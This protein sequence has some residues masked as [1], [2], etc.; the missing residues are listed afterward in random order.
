MI[1]IVNI[2]ETNLVHGLDRSQDVV[3]MLGRRT[4]GIEIATNQ[5]A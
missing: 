3:V 5:F 1:M 4:I 2:R